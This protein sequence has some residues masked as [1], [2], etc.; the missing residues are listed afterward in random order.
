MRLDGNTALA[1]QLHRI[2]HLIGHFAITQTAAKLYKPV[3]QRGFAMIDVR[4]DGK[5][6][7]ILHRLRIIGRLVTETSKDMEF[8]R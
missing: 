7:D 3:R 6:A 1:F 8:I 4:D 2:Q 5:I